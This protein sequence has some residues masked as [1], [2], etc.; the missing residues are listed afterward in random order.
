MPPPGQKTCAPETGGG[1]CLGAGEGESMPRL[2]GQENEEA[3]WGRAAGAGPE[4]GLEVCDTEC[5]LRPARDLAG[6]ASSALRGELGQGQPGETQTEPGPVRVA[7]SG[8]L[9]PKN[10]VRK[11]CR[12]APLTA[13]ST[14]LSLL[15][16]LG[17]FSIRGSSALVSHQF[18]WDAAVLG[19]M[20][21][22]PSSS[23]AGAG[24]CPGW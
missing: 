23:S 10:S 21:G 22:V 7:R 15:L 24:R 16:S 13:A 5:S 1:T 19:D 2:A 3:G 18:L 9:K 14:R 20:Q 6:N 11:G 8:A 4:W 17:Q 12:E